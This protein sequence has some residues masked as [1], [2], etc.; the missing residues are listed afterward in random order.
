MGRGLASLDGQCRAL[1]C[2][3]TLGWQSRPEWALS[4]HPAEWH[5]FKECQRPERAVQSREAQQYKTKTQSRR[6]FETLHFTIKVRSQI[7]WAKQ[8]QLSIV[9]GVDV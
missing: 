5:A 3:F 6:G 2:F 8:G 7:T 4:G 1:F 9:N